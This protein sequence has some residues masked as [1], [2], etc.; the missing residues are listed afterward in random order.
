MQFADVGDDLRVGFGNKGH[1]GGEETGATGCSIFQVDAHCATVA[2]HF[3]IGFHRA[4]HHFFDVFYFV[5]FKEQIVHDEVTIFHEER[6][7]FHIA[8]KK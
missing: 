8:E 4:K 5:F 7:H 1:S 3:G 2:T 6:M